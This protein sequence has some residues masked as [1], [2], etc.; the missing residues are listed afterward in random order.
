MDC[1]AA[2]APAAIMDLVAP[3]ASIEAPAMP[4]H[5]ADA[6][7]RARSSADDLIVTV[8]CDRL[9][10]EVDQPIQI[11]ALDPERGRLAGWWELGRA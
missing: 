11:I 5:A 6:P 9:G 1:D 4:E 7:L 10:C 3:V 2:M 8:V